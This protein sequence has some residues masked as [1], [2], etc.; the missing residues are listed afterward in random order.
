MDETAAIGSPFTVPRN[1]E[2]APTITLEPPAPAPQRSTDDDAER[3]LFRKLFPSGYPVQRLMFRS[4]SKP[5]DWARIEDRFRAGFTVGQERDALVACS[6]WIA[7]QLGLKTGPVDRN[8][9]TLTESYFG[10]PAEPLQAAERIKELLT[11]RPAADGEQT[12]LADEL[13]YYEQSLTPAGQRLGKLMAVTGTLDFRAIDRLPESDQPYVVEYAM[14]RAG[15]E[16]GTFVGG[17]RQSYAALE[18]QIQNTLGGIERITQ[19]NRRYAARAEHVGELSPERRQDIERLQQQLE[20]LRA[21]KRHW[22]DRA[23]WAAVGL[24]PYGIEA[25]TGIGIIPMAVEAMN[26]FATR[27]EQGGLPPAKATAVASA[28]AP[29][30]AFLWTK[31]VGAIFKPI[32]ALRGGGAGGA[33]AI[34]DGIKR[35][36]V[37]R[38]ARLIPEFVKGA[39]RGTLNVSVAAGLEEAVRQ[40]A[41]EEGVQPGKTIETILHTAKESFL[42][43]L[44]AGGAAA[45]IGAALARGQPADKAA[46]VAPPKYPEKP[47]PLPEPTTK[48]GMP[49]VMDQQ[50]AR[51][52]AIE[53][54]ATERVASEITSVYEAAMQRERAATLAPE[55]KPA[56]VQAV[57]PTKAPAPPQEVP[58]AAEGRTPGP[59]VGPES[60][61]ETGV[62]AVQRVPVL[63]T[64]PDRGAPPAEAVAAPKAPAPEAKPA[65]EYFPKQRFAVG[66]AAERNAAVAAAKLA[67]I[68]EAQHGG[69]WPIGVPTGDLLSAVREFRRSLVATGMKRVPQGSNLETE[70]VRW[71]TKRKVETPAA[72]KP[73]PPAPAPETA[74]ATEVA[75]PAP[76]I[77]PSGGGLG[78]L[79]PAGKITTA[80]RALQDRVATV[81]A[82]LRPPEAGPQL[83]VV[84]DTTSPLPDYQ[85]V[86]VSTSMFATPHAMERVP[87]LGCL[88]GGRFHAKGPIMRAIARYAGE[89]HGVAKA[90]AS[91]VGTT[92]R[93]QVDVVFKPDKQG[94]V[95]VEPYT[96]GESLKITDVFESVRRG[97][98][99]YRLTPEQTA[100]WETTL[101]PLLDRLTQLRERYGLISTVDPDGDGHPDGYFPR[102]VTKRPDATTTTPT[103]ERVGAKQGFQKER[104]FATEEEGW[105]R[106]YQYETSIEARLVTS[107]ERTYK[108]MADRR[109]VSDATLGG[110]SRAIKIAEL[111]ETYAE[112]LAA[113]TKTPETI[114]R[115][116][117][118]LESRGAVY[119]PGFAGLIFDPA[120]AEVLNRELNTSSSNTRQAIAQA[121]SI[122]KAMRLGLDF[123]VGQLQGL[124]LLLSTSTRPQNGRIW[125]VAQVNALQSFANANSFPRYL[126]MPENY[127]AAMELA[128]GGSSIGSL[129]EMVAGLAKGQPVERIPVLGR[130]YGAF[131]R[132][133]QTFLDVAKIE[134]WKS[135]R[136]GL[137]KEQWPQMI[138][139]IESI[140]HM[141]RME[142]AGLARN[143]VLFERAA[144]LAPSFY[145]GGLNAISGAL[146]QGKGPDA[147]R[148]VL[149]GELAGGLALFVGVGLGLGMTWDDLKRGLDIGNPSLFMRWPI[150]LDNGTVVYA[151]IGGF[152]LG[153]VKLAGNCVRTCIETPGNWGSLAPDKN[154]IV[155]YLRAHLAPVPGYAWDAFS[156]KDFMGKPTDI[157]RS[158]EQ[159]V[160]LPATP[161]ISKVE[162]VPPTGIETAVSF[163]GGTAYGKTPYQQ[164]SQKAREFN[165]QQG[166]QD[167]RATFEPSPFSDL[168]WA[169]RLGRKDKAIAEL[170]KLLPK[171]EV[172][173]NGNLARNQVMEHYRRMSRRLFT[174]AHRRESAFVRSLSESDRQMYRRVRRENQ[175]LSGRAR[176]AMLAVRREAN[177]VRP[178]AMQS[179]D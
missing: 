159:I 36:L 144:L 47:P 75:P 59:G 97:E 88:F 14:L 139:A 68:L 46:P 118:G 42:P 70:T 28:T 84:F 127:Q 124:P 58:R 90:I 179:L 64:A 96:P 132:Q 72:P 135:Y 101:K 125:A 143:R 145:R 130:A 129:P 34:E 63:D 60:R 87:G 20:L 122:S 38:A 94:N 102:I 83:P 134:L 55:A 73:P 138:Q 95:A 156:G 149:A 30:V 27:L 33:A 69:K 49:Y 174:G 54:V 51:A 109:L 103:G 136:E 53:A 74:P 81:V 2:F 24:V 150:R 89:R 177:Q 21:Q 121:N 45:G 148:R 22:L 133:F 71:V 175:L 146:Q 107:I 152:H 161:Y 93:G 19:E 1:P 151:G 116:V 158:V 104:A 142:S 6:H 140:L 26:S 66:S 113:G 67:N 169:L 167:V 23:G 168:D 92:L 15:L 131:G 111:S 108:A 44:L 105:A 147:M 56:Q 40:V 65:V 61:A 106:G 80:G 115:M 25:Q 16:P 100:V 171:L 166:V 123:G 62:G 176:E 41:T 31:G 99:R 98:S 4:D 85:T 155:R 120:V 114:D 79:T 153:L 78:L 7:K 9:A 32:T 3:A 126:R 11:P 91:T 157:W 50:T 178:T 154:P 117:D 164:L 112:E 170:K 5:L 119:Q 137:P 173:G 18:L 48:P 128:Q 172:S 76:E 77:A 82:A 43:F 141:G 160:P 52:K 12:T 162:K 86:P 8:F 163:L 29:V 110:K 35:K 17:V 37:E 10:R 39:G 165:R 13:S 57:E